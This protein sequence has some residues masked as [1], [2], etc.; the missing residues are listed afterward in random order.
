MTSDPRPSRTARRTS[1]GRP[2]RPRRRRRPGSSPRRRWRRPGRRP[3]ADRARPHRRGLRD[4]DARRLRARRRGGRQRPDRRPRGGPRGLRRHRQGPQGQPRLSRSSA[5]NQVDAACDAVVPAPYTGCTATL[6]V[7][8]NR[9][10]AMDPA[11]SAALNAATTDGIYVLG[12]DQEIAMDVL[13]GSPAEAAITAGVRQ[14]GVVLGGT[15]AGAAVE[16]RNMINGYTTLADEPR[17]RPAAQLDA[18]VVG[19]RRHRPRARPRRRLLQGDLRPAL[20]PAR[21]LRAHPVHP[22][23]RRRAV[24]RSQPGGR[25]GRLRDRHP[26]HRRHDALRPVRRQLG[27]RRRPRDPARD[28][29]VG[30][31]PGHAVRPQ[32]ADPPDDRR[33]GLRPGQPGVHPRWRGRRAARLRPVGGPG[34][35]VAGRRH[36]VPRRR[37]ARH[38]RRR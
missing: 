27:G 23:H 5:P 7:L 16:S 17:A 10:D 11:N 29:H 38:G 9:A 18:D 24:R 34:L 33:H 19:R 2:A 37:R 12:G 15:S 21:P 6:A 4:V 28:P 1:R 8:L 25:R 3:R 31:Q 26:R 30:R 36:R 13:A 35:P 14:R 22:G 32:R 20:L